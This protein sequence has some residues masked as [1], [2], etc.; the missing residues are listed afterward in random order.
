[1]KLSQSWHF[2][3]VVC[4]FYA[5]NFTRDIQNFVEISICY[6]TQILNEILHISG[7][8]ESTKKT[9]HI[10][11][12]T[13]IGIFCDIIISRIFI[14]KIRVKNY[15]K[16][17]K[18]IF[19]SSHYSHVQWDTLYIQRRKPSLTRSS[20]FKSKM[21]SIQSHPS[22]VTLQLDPQDQGFQ[23]KFR[24]F[25]IS[26]ARENGKHLDRFNLF[27]KKSFAKKNA[28]IS[29]KKTNADK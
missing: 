10:L 2:Q 23:R 24:I 9:D 29:R 26:F 1:M 15:I 18:T 22:W 5:V 7:N 27:R 13:G 28:K 25:C 16:N 6:K 20:Y 11:E 4:L 8:I 3:N 17:K 12:I 14:S 21:S 19:K